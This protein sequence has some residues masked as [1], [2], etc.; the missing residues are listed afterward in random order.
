MINLVTSLGVFKC[1]IKSGRM[2]LSAKALSDNIK[3]PR[4]VVK[5][6]LIFISLAW[7]VPTEPKLNDED[8]Y[9]LSPKYEDPSVDYTFAFMVLQELFK[10]LTTRNRLKLSGLKSPKL[11][12]SG[13]PVWGILRLFTRGH[14]RSK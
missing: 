7:V 12:H 9:Y 14:K 10:G 11:R 13:C 8:C 6:T 1:L 3:A 5:N 4:I 2:Q